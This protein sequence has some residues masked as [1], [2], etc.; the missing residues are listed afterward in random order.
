[1]RE[2]KFHAPS[3]AALLV[4]DVVRVDGQVIEAELRYG[5]RFPRYVQQVVIDGA[6]FGYDV[7]IAGGGGG[8]GGSGGEEQQQGQ[9]FPSAFALYAG[10]HQAMWRHFGALVHR[11]QGRGF[12]HCAAQMRSYARTFKI[13]DAAVGFATQQLSLHNR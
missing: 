11:K 12:D 9:V 5:R 2:F 10:A 6:T 1:M 4:L 3:C 7:R 8:Q 13:L